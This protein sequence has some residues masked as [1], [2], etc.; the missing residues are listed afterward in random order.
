MENVVFNHI[1]AVEFEAIGLTIVTNTYRCLIGL[2]FTTTAI[3]HTGNSND[4]F[5]EKNFLFK[6][7]HIGISIR[8]V[9]DVCLGIAHIDIDSFGFYGPAKELN[10]SYTVAR[11]LTDVFTKFR[12]TSVSDMVNSLPAIYRANCEAELAVLEEAI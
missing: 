8:C 12:N 9:Y 3:T 1:N 4:S 2:G 7:D 10:T 6:N 5:V 11:M